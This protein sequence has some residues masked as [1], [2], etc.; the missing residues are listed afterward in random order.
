MGHIAAN[1][2]KFFAFNISGVVKE[3]SD[4]D[5][6]LTAGLFNLLFLLH[7]AEVHVAGQLSCAVGLEATESLVFLN[8]ANG[9][10]LVRTDRHDLAF[11]IN[12]VHGKGEAV[13]LGQT[14]FGNITSLEG[15]NTEGTGG[16]EAFAIDEDALV[17]TGEVNL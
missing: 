2:P 11:A 6:V 1:S 4:I 15:T 13:E 5:V 10:S 9:S 12:A 8:I 3:V 7:F 16:R 17:L 14:T